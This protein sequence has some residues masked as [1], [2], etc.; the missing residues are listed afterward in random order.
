MSSG[1]YATDLSSPPHPGTQA[2]RLQAL[3]AV[4][5]GALFAAYAGVNAILVPTRIAAMDPHHKVTDVAVVAGLSA[6]CAMVA[7]PVGGAL[8]DR[9]VSRF[10]KRR[11]WLVGGACGALAGMGLLAIAGSLPMLVLA[12]CLTQ[13]MLNVFQAALTAIVPDRIPVSRRGTV[14]AV[15]GVA[16]AVG[17][18]GGTAGAAVLEPSRLAF[19][20]L[21]LAVLVAALL[22]ARLPEPPSGEVTAQ[23]GED[24]ANSGGLVRW[25]SMLRHGDLAWVF[26]GR[27]AMILSYNLVFVY[28]LYIVADYVRKPAGLSAARGVAVLTVIS[29]VTSIVAII[30]GGVL[31]DRLRR[32]RVFVFAAGL[33]GGTA[34]VLPA[35]S[36]SWHVILA[37]AAIEGLAIGAYLAVDT[38]LVTLVLPNARTAARDLGVVNIA[39]AGPPVLAPFIAST[40]V[41]GAGYRAVFIG[42]AAIA[43]LASV[44]IWRVRGVR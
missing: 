7:N 5:N 3:L 10:G 6:V 12:Q 21:G 25:L 39:N 4:A 23:P 41:L 34:M 32:Y 36:P 29:V 14:S 9:T 2:V 30:T 37:C 15:I 8:S 28:L 16:V 20:L 13:A 38:A 17:T 40:I 1:G 24:T 22:M 18:A 43:L 11:P 27:A 42:S 19:G 31:S 35:V 26:A 44:T 33:L